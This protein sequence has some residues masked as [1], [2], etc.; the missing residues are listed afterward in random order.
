MKAGPAVAGS[1]DEYIAAYP[2][3]VQAILK[4]VRRTIREVVPE[5]R[6]AIKY[7]IPTFVLN[8]NL[9]HFA[10]FKNHIGFYPTASGI[11]QFKAELAGYHSAKGSVQF[12]LDK[13]VPYSLVRKITQFRA[14]EAR[15]RT[16]ARKRK[17]RRPN[18]QSRR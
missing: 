12:P 1:I 13:P 6:E 10:A 2:Q 18:P 17:P 5:A 9:V 4:E 11:R 8:E 15:E 3:N 14:K 7:R 16:A